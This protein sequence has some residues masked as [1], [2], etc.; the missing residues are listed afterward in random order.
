[1]NSTRTQFSAR[2]I[3]YRF[4]SVGELRANYAASPLHCSRVRMH[5]YIDGMETAVSDYLSAGESTGYLDLGPLSPG[6][7]VVSFRAEGLAGGCNPGWLL[8]WGGQVDIVR[9]AR[10]C[11]FEWLEVERVGEEIRLTW[12]QLPG[13][14]LLESTTVEPPLDGGSEVT[15]VP[16]LMGDRLTVIQGISAGS[17]HYRLRLE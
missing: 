1:M 15:E 9:A 17:R 3:D 2:S 6:A 4:W 13:R 11:D 16:E 14:F 5:F 10:A 12:P 7:H 8:G